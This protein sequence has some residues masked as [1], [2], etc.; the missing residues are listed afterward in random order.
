MTELDT[1]PACL[2]CRRPWPRRA[3]AF[4]GLLA[5]WAWPAAVVGAEAK[6]TLLRTPN[7]GIQPQA[8]VDAKGALHL[9]YFKGEAGGGDL[10]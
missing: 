9:I 1:K 3:V 8:V 4:L 7:G 2:P 6:V 10:F 5:V